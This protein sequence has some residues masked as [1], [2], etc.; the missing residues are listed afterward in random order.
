M[1]NICQPEGIRHL[2]PTVR[3][4]HITLHGS[5]LVVPAAELL[6][7]IGD[8]DSNTYTV[9]FSTMLQRDLDDMPEHAG[10]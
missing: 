5:T 4:A 6:D 7:H 8:D 2:V 1:S 3:V 9:R 10:F